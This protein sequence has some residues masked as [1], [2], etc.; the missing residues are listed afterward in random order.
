MRHLSHQILTLFQLI[1]LACRVVTIQMKLV[2]T[3][4]IFPLLR[5]QK[6]HLKWHY[7]HLHRLFDEAEVP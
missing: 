1:Q 7:M 6:L 4:S 5:K 2:L 3:N